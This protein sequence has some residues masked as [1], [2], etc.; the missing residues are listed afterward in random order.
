M[1][2]ILITT[3]FT[4]FILL[5]LTSCFSGMFEIYK[6]HFSTND[7]LILI[8][9]KQY[10]GIIKLNPK[11]A[12]GHFNRG[13]CLIQIGDSDPYRAYRYNYYKKA[14]TDFEEA[15]NLNPNAK[16]IDTAYFYRGAAIFK[17]EI[18]EDKY[19]AKVNNGANGTGFGKSFTT[20]KREKELKKAVVYFNKAI[21]LNPKYADAYFQRGVCDEKTA[22]MIDDFTKAI[23]FNTNYLT[24]A[25]YKRGLCK[26]DLNNKDGGC[27]DIEK[28][29]S[30]GSTDAQFAK[31]KYCK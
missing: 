7:S 21:E 12:G 3:V 13:K 28:A 1:N 11:D 25:Y 8:K 20:I 5:A 27:E 22:E 9:I 10:T 18:T 29:I 30:L 2:K 16:N 23:K 31:I 17:Y 24:E 6:P 15:L 14:K 26:F 19:E 4:L